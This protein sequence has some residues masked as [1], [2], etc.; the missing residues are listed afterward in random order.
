VRPR[1]AVIE[2]GRGNTYGHPTP[3]TLGTLRRA[4]VR[5]LRT[6]RDGTVVVD[7]RAGRMLVHTRS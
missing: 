4:G 3:S 5:T 1:L 7:V 6:D 2:V